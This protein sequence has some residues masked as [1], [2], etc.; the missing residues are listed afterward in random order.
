MHEVSAVA[1]PEVRATRDFK[2]Q[3]TLATATTEDNLAAAFTHLQTDEAR[4]AAELV[5]CTNNVS[6]VGNVEKV[7]SRAVGDTAESVGALA[8]KGVTGHPLSA[9]PVGALPR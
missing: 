4:D 5:A 1:Q 9:P 2:V 8:D 3:K 6:R 7:N